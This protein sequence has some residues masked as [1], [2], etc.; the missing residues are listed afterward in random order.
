MERTRRGHGVNVLEINLGAG[1]CFAGGSTTSAPGLTY[2]NPGS[3]TTSQF[4]T[5]D[6]SSAGN[7]LLGVIVGIRDQLDRHVLPGGS[8]RSPQSRRFD[9]LLAPLGRGREIDVCHDQAVYGRLL[10][11]Q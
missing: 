9:R 3:P 4:A 10:D 2:Q 6:I 1:Y 7:V 8:G 11:D 5:I